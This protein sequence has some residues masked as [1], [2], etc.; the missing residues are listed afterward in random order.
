VGHAQAGDQVG[1]GGEARPAGDHRLRHHLHTHTGVGIHRAQ[2]G[3]ILYWSYE[4]AIHNSNLYWIYP[5]I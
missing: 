1:L 2:F 3:Q 4:I 5:Q